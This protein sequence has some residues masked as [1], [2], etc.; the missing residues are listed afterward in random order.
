MTK[1]KIAII[2]DTGLDQRLIA[3]FIEFNNAELVVVS[4]KISAPKNA[5]KKEIER[6]KEKH[7]EHVCD[8]MQNVDSLILPGNKDDINPAHYG[9]TF[10]HPETQKK[11]NTDPNNIRFYVEK[12]MLLSAIDRQLPI[13]AI[14]AGM[15]LVNVVM[16]GTLIQNIPDDC[17]H[18][19]HKYDQD[20]DEQMIANWEREFE[21]HVLTG[22]PPSIYNEHP[23]H[24]QIN[25]D[26]TLG[27]IYKK[28][29]IDINLDNIHEVSMHHQGYRKENLA[30]NLKVVAT[31]SDGL[32]EAVEL[33]DYPSLFVATQYHFEY[34]LGKIANGIFKELVG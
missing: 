8:I 15:Q 16:G 22:N 26:S 11:L 30:D 23:H 31:S 1:R 20:L 29:L 2:D 14:C 4:K 19:D 33:I 7:L 3:K 34:N 13:V 12:T 32:I 10:I 18:I 25:P 27:K 5:G 6:H 17:G 24:V 21:S 28:Y 9:E